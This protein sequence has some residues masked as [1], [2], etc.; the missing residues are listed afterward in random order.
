MTSSCPSSRAPREIASAPLHSGPRIADRPPG[1]VHHLSDL[2]VV[3]S[4]GWPR[5]LAPDKLRLRESVPPGRLDTAQ[6][7]R[8][9]GPRRRATAAPPEWHLAGAA[10]QPEPPVVFRTGLPRSHS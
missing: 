3:A 6:W 2:H 7:V 1:Q 4:T 5:R 9:T 8:P 10:V